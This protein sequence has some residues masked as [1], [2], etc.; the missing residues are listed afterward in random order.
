MKPR[1]P[2]VYKYIMYFGGNRE[3]AI[4]R[5]GEKCLH[6]GM[7]RQEH[8]EKYRRDITVDHIDGQ[9]RYSKIKN[10][11]LDNLQT[12]CVQCHARKDRLI[13]IKSALYK[14]KPRKEICIRGHKFSEYGR[15][16]NE[17]K[18]VLIRRCLLCNRIREK[19]KRLKIRGK[20]S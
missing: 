12:L 15:F 4:K 11:S 7:T 18:G 1:K 17:G 3:I 6:C 9:G 2:R 20:V 8:K 16:Y 13:F 14:P 19:K 10:N 5:D